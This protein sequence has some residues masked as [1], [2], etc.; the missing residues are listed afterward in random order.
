MA[1]ILEPFSGYVPTSELAP[2]VVG[3]PISTLSP[4]QQ[5]A[6]KLDPL[7][8][9]HVVGKGAGSDEAEARQWLV[10]CEREGAL[11]P[12][13]PAVLLYEQ[14]TDLS[15][16]RGVIT[17]VL[18]GSYDS[19]FI[20]KHEMTIAKSERRMAKYMRSTRVH[21]NPVVLAHRPNEMMTTFWTAN[22]DREPDHSYTAADGVRHSIWVV[23]EERSREFCA[24][25]R[26]VLYITDGHHRLA[27]ASSIATSEGR[28]RAH[29]P[30][31]IFATDQMELRTFARAVKCGLEP[32]EIVRRL[33][34]SHDLVPSETG[35]PTQKHELGVEVEGS[36]FLIRFDES[37]IPS[38]L[39][40]SLDVN[41]L[42]DQILEP[43]FGIEDPRQDSRLRFIPDVAGEGNQDSDVRFLPYPASVDDVLSV[44]DAGL[45]M[46]P[47]STWFAPK[48][49]SGLVIRLLQ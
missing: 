48:L 3:P 9:R 43:L 47:K 40:D 4:D 27:A 25:F 20:K 30:A 41:V 8:F 10:D 31:G 45:A 1:A 44:A 18:I 2:R 23:N 12:V 24:G 5:S 13:G 16:A 7:S 38:G 29:L 39:Y 22:G 32:D 6:A 15:T 36:R 34:E 11:E 49:P 37:K 35:R 28:L 42:Q 17:D 21:G 46:P 26:E 33:V 14:Q 19:G